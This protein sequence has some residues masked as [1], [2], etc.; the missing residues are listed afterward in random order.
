MN[1]RSTPSAG[2]GVR[3]ECPKRKNPVDGFE[4]FESWLARK[5]L[6]LGPTDYG[7]WKWRCINDLSITEYDIVALGS[8]V[9]GKNRSY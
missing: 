5:N 4:V 2:S 8:N 9:T 7:F 1:S 6:N 3:E